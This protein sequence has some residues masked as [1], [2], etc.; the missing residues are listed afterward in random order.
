MGADNQAA[1][2]ALN[3]VKSTAGQYIADEILEMAAKIKKKTEELR[4][5][6]AHI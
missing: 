3:S 2:G 1:L 6:L 4:Q 5:L